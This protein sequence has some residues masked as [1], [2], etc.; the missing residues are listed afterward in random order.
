M[1]NRKILIGVLG[2]LFLV[3]MPLCAEEIHDAALNGDINKVKSLLAKNP[4]LIKAKDNE[5]MTPLHMAAAA[6]QK[7]VA[8]LLIAKGADVNAKSNDG[9]TPLQMAVA[10]GQ[11]EVAEFLKSHG[12]K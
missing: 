10:W 12:G 1:T 5:G 2:I 11:K 7:E 8:E 9:V 6:G 3:V 4:K